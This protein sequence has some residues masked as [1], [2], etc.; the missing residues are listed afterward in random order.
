VLEGETL[1]II[2]EE[3]PL[4][5]VPFDNI[6]FQGPVP[7]TAILR[8]AGCPLQIVVLPLITAVGRGLTVTVAGPLRSAAIAVQF[9]SVRATT[10]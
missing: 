5:K 8:L 3:L 9:A 2:G 7:V 4:N 10:E 6:P 1:T